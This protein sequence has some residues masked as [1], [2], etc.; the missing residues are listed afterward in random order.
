MRKLYSLILPVVC[1]C[2]MP[3]HAF[4]DNP[5]NTKKANKE[6]LVLMHFSMGDDSYFK[7][8]AMEL[9]L[10]QGLQHKYKV[11]SG[12]EVENISREIAGKRANP[13]QKNCDDARCI[14]DVAIAFLTELVATAHVTKKANDYN[15]SLNIRD[16]FDNKVIYSN[17]VECINCDENK[18]L[19]KFKE[20]GS[21]S[22][23]ALATGKPDTPASAVA[24]ASAVVA[25]TPVNPENTLWNE[26]KLANTQESYQNYL[27]QYPKGK[28]AALS[29]AHISRIKEEAAIEAK[30]IEDLA[31]Q[32]VQNSEDGNALQS[33]LTQ[34]PNGVHAVEAQ[35]KLD[36]IQ[37]LEVELK[38]GRIFNDCPDCPEMVVLPAGNFFMGGDSK[39]DGQPI[40][41][42][43][44]AK[45][46][47]M[48]KTEIT[49]S[50]WRA[51]MGNNPSK[52]PGCGD[53]CPVEQVSW[54]EVKDFIQKLNTKTGKQY[55]LPSEAEWEYAC[56][57]GELHKYCGSDNEDSVGWYR[58]NSKQKTHPVAQKQANAF[59]LYDMGGNVA[60]WVEDSYH[61]DYNGAPADGSAWVGGD[62]HRV[63]RGSSWGGKPQSTG[64]AKRGRFDPALR[65][66]SFGFRLARVMP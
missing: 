4:A 12:E 15:L 39:L 44:L 62:V 9:A 25:G 57:G 52:F 21:E 41:H 55:R 30:R 18:V 6:S 22:S 56:R 48:S 63:V 14:E 61:D 54:N 26:S 45:P 37:K 65:G 19:G 66:F 43:T 2:W 16:V 64:V 27:N 3:I 47:A 50:Q 17:S 59:G 23:E 49:Q 32:P 33:F 46:F 58:D 31:W 53:N 34:H 35:A 5:V 40:H 51:I 1:L 24:A 11:I 36:A 28:F 29:N 42:V 8:E 20:L 7:T 60:E 38:P 13:A 10:A